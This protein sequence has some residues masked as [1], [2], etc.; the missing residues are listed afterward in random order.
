MT[1][2]AYRRFDGRQDSFCLSRKQEEVPYCFRQYIAVESGTDGTIEKG[3]G[4]FVVSGDFKFD[5][6]SGKSYGCFF[7]DGGGAEK[8][9]R[10]TAFV[11]GGSFAQLH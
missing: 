6:F 8:L 5:I 7:I 2:G 3:I 11:K 10:V 4:D 9:Q 1:D